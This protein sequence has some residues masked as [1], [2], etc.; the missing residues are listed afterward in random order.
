MTCR[1]CCNLVVPPDKSGR[2]VA[3]KDKAYRCGAPMSQPKL[4]VS[5]TGCHSFRW[6][7]LQIYM[8][9]DDGADCP[10]YEPI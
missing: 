9:P 7:L 5:V 10:C 3:R 2:R 8:G 6:P 4:P 1:S